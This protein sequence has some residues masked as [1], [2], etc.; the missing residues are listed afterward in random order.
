MCTRAVG[1][2]AHYIEAEGI[3]TTQISL[4][5]IHTE[6][7]RPPRALWVPF[8]LGR[9]LGAPNDPGFQIKV[10]RTVLGLLE[11]S[12]GPILEDFP[13]E[14]PIVADD[15]EAVLACPYVPGEEKREPNRLSEDFVREINSLKPWYLEAKKKSAE[16]EFGVSQLGID[17]IAQLFSS[18]LCGERLIS[19]DSEVLR[20]A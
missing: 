4:I 9:P 2:L 15:E 17:E 8:E 1:A 10:I 18:I 13:E 19:N 6:K 3:A 16:E 20:V 11:V 14:A 12:S 5:R 7:I